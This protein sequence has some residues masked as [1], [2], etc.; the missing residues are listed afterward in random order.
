MA[1]LGA[2]ELAHLEEERRFLLRSLDDLEREH[3]AGDVDAADYAALRDGY[4]K[5]AAVVLAE[6]ERGTAQFAARPRTSWPRRIVATVVVLALAVGIGAVAARFSGQRLSS[7]SMTGDV[8]G[9]NR[10]AAL[11]SDARLSLV[12]GDVGA[13]LTAGQLYDQVLAEDPDNP[14]ALAYGGWVAYLLSVTVALDEIDE[15]L[16]DAAITKARVQLDAAIA[17]DPAYPDPL[18]FRAILAAR[19]DDDVVAA[20]DYAERCLAFDPPAAFA[21]MME[22]FVADLDT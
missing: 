11:L 6:I 2:D 15:S 18:C 12:P 10:V 21:T 14:E 20:R 9:R 16:R 22:Q 19:A 4:V 1:E 7:D 3:A 13:L 8:I 17:A 5:R